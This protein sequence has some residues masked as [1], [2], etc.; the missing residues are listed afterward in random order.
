[1]GSPMHDVRCFGSSSL[2]KRFERVTPSLEWR[3]TEDYPRE[4][5]ICD[6]Q[7]LKKEYNS[8]SYGDSLKVGY[9]DAQKRTPMLQ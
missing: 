3:V 1:M 5:E 9:L 2:V 6:W 7:P 4:V 8:G